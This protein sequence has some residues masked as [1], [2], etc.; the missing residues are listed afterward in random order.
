MVL[1]NNSALKETGNRGREM[2]EV[3][4]TSY[5]SGGITQVRS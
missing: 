4:A 1:G 3:R 2:E 5:V